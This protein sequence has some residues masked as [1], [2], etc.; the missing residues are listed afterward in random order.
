MK[1][2]KFLS[3]DK[4]KSDFSEFFSKPISH[5]KKVIKSAVKD[6]N[7]EQKEMYDRYKSNVLETV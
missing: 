5:Q 4:E 7:K 2:F 6:A 1:L 3:K